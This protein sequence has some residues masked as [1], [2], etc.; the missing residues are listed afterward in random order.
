MASAVDKQPAAARLA[1]VAAAGCLPT[2]ANESQSA[3][4]TC[5]DTTCAGTGPWQ[6]QASRGGWD[7]GDLP[8][9]L[10]ASEE[11]A[12]RRMDDEVDGA[13]P[14]RAAQVIEELLAVDADDRA[15]ALEARPVGRVSAAAEGG[16]DP[17]EGDV[18]AGG[19]GIAAAHCR[20]PAKVCL[21]GRLTAFPFLYPSTLKSS[22]NGNASSRTSV[23]GGRGLR[24]PVR[25]GGCEAI[26]T[27]GRPFDAPLPGEALDGGNDGG[28]AGSG[29]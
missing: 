20:V 27:P 18:A 1:A 12:S 15:P 4:T 8:P 14:S 13:T 3:C 11:A 29:A 10:M 2:A 6:P 5:G 16:G 28:V 26:A 24:L 23:D 22:G 19:Q 17:V 25:L 21:E 9:P 7:G